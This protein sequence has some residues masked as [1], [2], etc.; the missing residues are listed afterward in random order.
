MPTSYSK[1]SLEQLRKEQLKISKAI[2]AK[3]KSRK[4]IVL[5][6]I[7]AVA[8]K[9]GFKLK[10]L[11]AQGE[12]GTGTPAR[13]AAATATKSPVAGQSA[14]QKS[15]SATRK[16]AK[17]KV[18]YINPENHSETWTGR[19]RQPRWVVAHID[20]GGSLQDISV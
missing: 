4:K 2:E 3:E 16:R 13:K 19:G 11:V 7:K 9:H 14:A 18:K 15:L 17:A 20:K 6:E 8:R 1:L 12:T 10:E 5:A